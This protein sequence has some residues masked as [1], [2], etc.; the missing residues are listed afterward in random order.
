MKVEVFKEEGSGDWRWRL[1]TSNG[2][3]IA[4]SG[5][6]YRRKGAAIKAWEKV[7]DALGGNTTYSANADGAFSFTYQ[8][9]VIPIEE[10]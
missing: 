4:D 2:R 6:G 3:T 10:V 7:R 9:A 8:P 5:E 1:V